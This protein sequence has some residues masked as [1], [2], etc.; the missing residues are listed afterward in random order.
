MIEVRYECGIYLSGQGLWLEPREA[1]RF[2]F[3]SHAHGD[4][5]APHEEIILSERTARLLQARMPGTRI[6]HVLPFGEQRR[7]HDADVTL[8]P[9]GHIFGSAQLFLSSGN[10]TLLYTGD[11]KLRHGKS[12]EAAEW[13]EADTLIME[14]TFGLPRYQFPPTEKV[15]EQ[16]VAFCRETI[17]NGQVPVLLGYSLGKAQEILC[18][19]E[20]AGLTPMLHGSVYQ[21]TR[22][23]EQFGQSFCKYVRYKP[24]DVTGKVLICPP[25]T[26]GSR[27]L[28]K[29]PRKRVAM[30]SGW[31]VEPNAIYRYRVDAAF[32][33]SDH[34]DYNDLVR[35]VDLVRPKRVLT[36]H[37]FAA[38]FA[39][40]LRERGLEAWALNVENQM[41]LQLNSPQPGKL[42]ATALPQTQDGAFVPSE[43]ELWAF[44]KVGEKIAA[45]AAKLEK[46][47]LLSDYL[48]TL[49]HKRLSLAATYFTGRA[50]PQSYLRTL[51]VG[52]SIIYRAIMAAA[53]LNEAEFRRIAHSHGDAGKT[54]FEALDGRTQP[55]PFTLCQSRDFFEALQKARGPVA[56]IDLL[57]SQLARLSALEGQ[58]LVKILSGDL[59]IGLREGL[60][61]DAIARAFQAPLD[62][63][64]Q[65]NMLLGDIGAAAVLGLRKELH[66]A[67]LSIF[68]PIKCMLARPE[69]T[70][71]AIW[72]RFADQKSPLVYAEDK[73]D[74]IRG[75]LHR[76]ASRVEI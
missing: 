4:H 18:S 31:A 15:I 36:L 27:L 37:G 53:K 58:Y 35:Y 64:K 17:E 23:Y 19:L 7:V 9:A 65:A 59:R 66:R 63:V 40:D 14:K 43:S 30:L 10:E 32:P 24:N 25:S 22:V 75:Q 48:R 8:L 73:F 11:F 47:S 67:E 57:Q 72:E 26:N 55:K 42:A 29:I 52:G 74:G 60:V 62:Q 49:D 56:K 38:E 54:A 46:I 2:A 5:I 21:M 6:E 41:D 50:F 13:R 3:I 39:R 68:R 34:A 76:D 61:E 69:P 51:Q 45:T 20:G 70:A 12:A 28:E 1:K 33:L 71:E 16:I 44:A